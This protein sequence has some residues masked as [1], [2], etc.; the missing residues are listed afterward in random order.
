MGATDSVDK[1]QDGPDRPPLPAPSPGGHSYSQ[2]GLN[3][4]GGKP[5]PA[6]NASPAPGACCG[7]GTSWWGRWQGTVQ[8]RTPAG[9]FIRGYFWGE[10]DSKAG[11]PGQGRG[12][13]KRPALVLSGGAAAIC[14]PPRS[15]LVAGA[16][17]QAHALCLGNMRPRGL[18]EPPCTL[19]K[20]PPGHR[21]WPGCR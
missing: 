2:A 15:Q 19:L 7:G 21:G 11:N 14:V 17:A 1:R 10:A 6:G 13:G 4:R 18:S 16:A 9:L 12:G 20:V 3:P 8:R 5:C